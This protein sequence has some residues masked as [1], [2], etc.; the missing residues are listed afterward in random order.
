MREE[1]DGMYYYKDLFGHPEEAFI[2]MIGLDFK[3]SL[4][5]RRN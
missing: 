5:K 3:K 4:K 2:S 1:F